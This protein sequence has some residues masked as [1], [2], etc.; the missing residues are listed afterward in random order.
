MGPNVVPI[1]RRAPVGVSIGPYII[2]SALPHPDQNDNRTTVAGG[3]KRFA[4]ATPK[5]SPSNLNRLRTFVRNWLRR[6][7]DCRVLA[8]LQD[9]SLDSWLRNAPYT[10]KRKEQLRKSY[11]ELRILAPRDLN[12]KHHLAKSFI[13]DE[14]YLEFK[15]ARCINSRSD[16]YKC[17]V[18]P[19][20]HAIEEKVFNMTKNFIKHV[21]IRDRPGWILE[22]VALPGARTFCTDFS[23][24]EAHFVKEIQE[25]IEME[26]YEYML[27]DVYLGRE[28]FELIKS[29]QAGKNVCQFKNILIKLGAVRL[30]GEMCTSLGNGFT[31]FMLMEFAKHELKI[32]GNNMHEGDDGLLSWYTDKTP[33]FFTNWFHDMGWTIKF[34]EPSSISEAS[35]CGLIFEEK[36]EQIIVDPFKTINLMGWLSA[37][38]TNA[39]DKKIKAILRCKALSYLYQY[40]GCPL[41]GS[42]ARYI[43]RATEGVRY[44]FKS[45]DWWERQKHMMMLSSMNGNWDKFLDERPTLDTRGLFESLFKVSTDVQERLECYFDSLTELGPL[46]HPNLDIFITQDTATYYL[47]YCQEYHAESILYPILQVAQIDIDSRKNES[48]NK[49]K[50]ATSKACIKTKDKDSYYGTIAAQAGAAL[51]TI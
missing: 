5:C 3:C 29:V 10:E 2:G 40:S 30:S 14:H 48:K 44:Q 6:S 50:Q 11:D 36:S 34:L 12:R 7:D 18:G 26:L 8:P 27:Q 35:F 51:Q 42:L 28:I 41:V 32:H 25:A 15:Q 22:H 23:T 13:K 4:A 9:V 24:F 38:Y 47:L 31:N 39:S 49:N 45:R 37:Q 21:P 1:V 33:E 17:L 43:I 16:Y 46:V 20:F 19:Y